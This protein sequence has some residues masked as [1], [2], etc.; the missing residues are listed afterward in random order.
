MNFKP[1]SWLLADALNMLFFGNPGF[2][3]FLIF[4]YDNYYYVANV[5]QKSLKKI[6]ICIIILWFKFEIKSFE[7][8]FKIC[9]ID[10]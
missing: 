5:F 8:N 6:Y 2:I 7:K 1:G 10:F 3:Y 4:K 9:F